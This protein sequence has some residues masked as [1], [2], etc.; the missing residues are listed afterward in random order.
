M[1][2]PLP[3]AS[4]VQHGDLVEEGLDFKML[5]DYLARPEKIGAR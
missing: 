3:Y 5:A 1:E 4:D 2:G